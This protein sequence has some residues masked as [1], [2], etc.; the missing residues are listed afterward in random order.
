M[1]EKT[2][3]RSI[4]VAAILFTHWHYTNGTAAWL[5]EGTEIWGHER[6]LPLRSLRHQ[7]ERK[8]RSKGERRTPTLPGSRLVFDILHKPLGAGV[9]ELSL[10]D[11]PA[12]I[13]VNLLEVDD[14]RRRG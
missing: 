13:F 3:G 6:I 4:K 7:I 8:R 10:R 14:E 12:P 9:L 11:V 1:L 5:D 2:L